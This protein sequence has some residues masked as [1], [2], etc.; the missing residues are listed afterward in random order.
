MDSSSQLGDSWDREFARRRRS[1]GYSASDECADS[2][3]KNAGPPEE[4]AASDTALSDTAASDTAA[5]DTEEPTGA[6]RERS[7]LLEAFVLVL[8]ALVLALTL[9]TYVAKAYE[10]KGKSME[11][12]FSNG[13]RVVVLKAFYEIQREDVIVFASSEDASKDLIKRV[14]GLPGETI[15]VTGGQVFINGRKLEEDYQT[16]HDFEREV[17]ESPREE[18]IPQGHYYVLGDNRPDSHDSRSFES[19]PQDSIRGKVVIRW[20][21]F[22]QF[23]AFGSHGSSNLP[24]PRSPPSLPP[25]G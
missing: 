12:T 5:S 4:T 20:W 16:R 9:K 17:R 22:G 13:Q 24:P 6:P 19:I 1:D 8:I 10:I 2:R 18:I 14:V 3:L 15:K 11:P 25:R 7:G 21:P 23:K